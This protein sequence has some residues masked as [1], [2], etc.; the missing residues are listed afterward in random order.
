MIDGTYKIEVDVPFGRK[1]GT[2]TLRTEGDTAIADID[3]PIV[4]KQHLKGRAE[5]DTF[6]AKGSGKIKFVGQID[7][8]LNGEVSG[9]DLVINIQSNKGE[10]KL[11]GIRA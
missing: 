9:N 3:A 10:F 6:T 4:G 2:V 8:T 1:T 7:Y 11:R 5:G